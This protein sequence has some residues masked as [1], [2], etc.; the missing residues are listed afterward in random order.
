MRKVLIAVDG[1]HHAMA[2]VHWVIDD[3]RARGPVGVFLLNVQ[4]A[5]I[6]YQTRGIAK[7]TIEAIAQEH[8]ADLTLAARE[9]LQTAGLDYS[10]AILQGEPAH[11]IVAAAEER[12]CDTIVMGSRGLGT[13]AGLFLGSVAIKVLHLSSVPVVL[14]K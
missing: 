2:A 1:S 12:D 5:A 4:P 7:E 9:S 8:G 11:V 3:A 14:V 6:P 13:V 10:W